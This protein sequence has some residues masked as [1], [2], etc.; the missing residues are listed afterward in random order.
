MF[1]KLFFYNKKT[2]LCKSSKSE[3]LCSRL[4]KGWDVFDGQI[5]YFTGKIENLRDGIFSQISFENIIKGENWSWFIWARK[6][7]TIFLWIYHFLDLWR[8][9]WYVH[10]S[11]I[12]ITHRAYCNISRFWMDCC[13]IKIQITKFCFLEDTKMNNYVFQ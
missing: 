1:F 12:I 7:K 13:A 6:T 2:W 11:T 8:R 3:V 10:H 4:F 9:L 5:S